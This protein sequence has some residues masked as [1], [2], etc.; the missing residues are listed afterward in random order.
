MT[1]L[2]LITLA[3]SIIPALAQDPLKSPPKV[4]L[5]EAY[6]LFKANKVP[7]ALEALV[8]AGKTNP[9][10]PPPKVQLALWYAQAGNGQSARAALEQAIAEDPNHP[11]G[12]LL[13]A[14]FA[15][16]DGRPTDAYLNLRTALELSAATRWTADQKSRFAREA[17][18]GLIET[19]FARGDLPAAKEYALELL[20]SDPKNGV[21]R[22]RLA[23][24]LF[25]MDKP[26]EAEKELAQAFADDPTIDPPELKLAGLWQ[27]R[28]NGQTDATKQAELLGTV[29]G[30]LQKAVT[31][32]PK[33]AKAAR[34]YGLWLLN[35]GKVAAAE[36]YVE[37]AGKLDPAGSETA[38]ARAVWALHK[39]DLATAE[40]LLEG[41]YKDAPGDLTTLSYL[42]LCLAES[43]DD[44]KEKRAV[45]LADTL[46][47]QN[48][49]AATAYAVLGWCQYK[50]GR[51]DEAERSLATAASAGQLTFD[52]AYFIARV[53]AGKQKY[54]DAHKLLTGAVAAPH[55]LFLYRADATALLA[56][57]AK[58]LPA[59][60]EEPKKQ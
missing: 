48:P 32:H 1:R 11:E 56:E 25:R 10:V 28:A 30:W 57:V 4:D 54:E 58:K 15:F 44:K 35:A 29:E 17:R 49:K 8:A 21:L 51:T 34:E 46:V 59:K 16:A 52:S 38:V 23:T 33:S 43:G 13:N 3:L 60:P 53:L 36:P 12:Y 47:R 42:C 22:S 9:A 27:G 18:N 7:E 26:A 50:A 20:N 5:N 31:R 45:D 24:I 19:C 2:T 40:P 6:D 41:A 39:K 14:N 37:A 55:G